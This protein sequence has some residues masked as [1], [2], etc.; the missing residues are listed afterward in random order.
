MTFRPVRSV[1]LGLALAGGLWAPSQAAPFEA[2]AT[3]QTVQ[4]RG[5]GPYGWH[6]RRGRDERWHDRRGWREDRHG[7]RDGICRPGLA[8]EKAARMGV[9]RGDIV[10]VTPRS[11]TV[12]GFRRGHPIA[13]RFAQVRGCPVIG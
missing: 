5:D 9:R 7:R 12:A 4:Y 3:V 8:L 1:L 6:E 10:R 13:V 11:V 2:P